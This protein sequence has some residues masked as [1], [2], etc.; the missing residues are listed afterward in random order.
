MNA[1]LIA[2]CAVSSRRDRQP[3]LHRYLFA[4]NFDELYYEINFRMYIHF[5]SIDFITTDDVSLF[6]RVKIEPQSIVKQ[7]S[8]MLAVDKCPKGPDKYVEENIHKYIDSYLWEIDKKEIINKYKSEIEKKYNII[9]D[10]RY[11][12]YNIQYIWEVES[13]K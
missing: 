3:K 8:F 10:N 6:K 1:A 2:A 9:I 11:F 5:N 13:V 4:D 7:R 12:D